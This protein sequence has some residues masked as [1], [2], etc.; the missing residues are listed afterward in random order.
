MNLK[1]GPPTVARGRG[2]RGRDREGEGDRG[3]ERETTVQR[4]ACS[5]LRIGGISRCMRDA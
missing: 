1:V 3:R 4:Y 5:A 2:K